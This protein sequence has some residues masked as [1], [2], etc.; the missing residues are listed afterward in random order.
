M[1]KLSSQEYSDACWHKV[2]DY[3]V[4][5]NDGTIIVGKYIKKFIKRYQH[6]LNEKEKYIYKVDK[7]DRVFKFFSFLNI[8]LKNKYEQF[9]LLPWQC[10]FIAFAFGFYYKGDEQKRVI[11]EAFLFMARKNGK[12]SFSAALQMYGMLFDGVAVP[13]SILLA[14][15]SQQASIALNFAKN[16]V[17][18][19]PELNE[20]IVGQRSRIIFKDYEKQGF[21]QIFSPVDSARLEG[22]S[23]SM[24]ILDEIH[25][26]EDNKIYQAI[27]TGTGA[28][29]NPMI[30]LIS[31]AGSKNNGFCNEYLKH[32]QNI[33]DGNII[34]ETKIAMIFQPD[35]EDD[36]KDPK[37]W[38]KSNPSLGV[39]N[40]IEDLLIAYN[41]AKHS[42]ADQYFFITKHLNVFYDEPDVWIPEEYLIPLFEEFDETL[43]YGKDAFIGMDLS[44]NTDLS[45]IVLYVNDKD[46]SYAIPYFWL[47]NM[48]GNVIR[49]NGKDLSNWIFDKYITKC[50]TKTI[51]LGLIYDK[52]IELSQKF[53]IISLQ[54]DPYN[55]PT[56]VSLLKDYGI[57]C[58]MFKQ[59]ASKFNSPMK[60]LEE[61]VYN[62]KIRMKNPV[63][64]WNFSNVVLYIDSNANIKIIK[65]KQ[66]DSVDGCVALAMAIGGWISYE[67]GE[68]LLGLQNYTDALKK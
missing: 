31:T 3:V 35:S 7:V 11:R 65:N 56:L 6:M 40:T 4:G 39:I 54:Y 41:G 13:Q 36:L 58:E 33:L 45:S 34:D 49:R 55:T 22:Y 59:N 17:I 23:P 12:T 57:N 20:R 15:T 64:L 62:K 63:L 50:D 1:N 8:E 19:T 28:R 53:N 16:M 67:F 37:C 38:V 26:Y 52:I 2:K 44:K 32:H 10:A 60:M 61:M 18:H 25:G 46:K 66:N 47:A 68:E 5:V 21:I 48:E 43:L 24:A 9:N 51:D 30:F 29:L 14:N 42:F 27:K